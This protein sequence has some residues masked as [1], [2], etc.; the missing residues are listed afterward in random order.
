MMFVRRA[1]VWTD[2][3]VKNVPGHGL[4][5]GKG[6]ESTGCYCCLAQPS[7]LSLVLQQQIIIIIIND[8]AVTS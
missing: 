1:V 2:L 8:A 5:R 6:L 4:K 7:T 3:A